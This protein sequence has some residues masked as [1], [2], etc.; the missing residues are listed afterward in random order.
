MVVKHQ[1][2]P[3]EMRGSITHSV[4]KYLSGQEFNN[5][6]LF[7]ILSALGALAWYGTPAMLNQIQQG[8]DRAQ[9]RYIED[10]S[11]IRQ[12]YERT[13]E[14]DYQVIQTLLRERGIELPST[15]RA[16]AR[17]TE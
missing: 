4:W 2:E 12:S 10:A 15:P 17:P 11:R 3:D 14:R 8:Y 1:P 5:V 16:S 13:S 6:M 9:S 7:L